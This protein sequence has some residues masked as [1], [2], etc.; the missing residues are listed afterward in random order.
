MAKRRRT[1]QRQYDLVDNI[2]IS[3]IAMI[4]VVVFAFVTL[5]G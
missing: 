1:T 2:C 5:A 3:L 4:C